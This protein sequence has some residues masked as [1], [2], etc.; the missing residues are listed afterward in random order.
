[1]LKVLS[2][3][4][5]MASSLMY[6]Q[7]GAKIAQENQEEVPVVEELPFRF[8]LLA[9]FPEGLS[10]TSLGGKFSFQKISLSQ[11]FSFVKDEKQTFIQ[12]SSLGEYLLWKKEKVDFYGTFGISYRKIILAELEREKLP[13]DRISLLEAFQLEAMIGVG[14]E[15]WLWP[16]ATLGFSQYFSYRFLPSENVQMQTNSSVIR[17]ALYVW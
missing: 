8:A 5:L 3:F 7:Y 1:M 6:G 9:A 16:W 14:A 10:S 15:V 11:Y 12:G 2:L 4:F 17:V 13:A